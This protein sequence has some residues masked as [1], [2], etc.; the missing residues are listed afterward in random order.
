MFESNPCFELYQNVEKIFFGN[1]FFEKKFM[2]NVSAFK[3]SSYTPPPFL[4]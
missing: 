2:Q 4:S 3:L 1:D